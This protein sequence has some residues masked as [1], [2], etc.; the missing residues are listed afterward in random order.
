M[1][2]SN[3][4]NTFLSST[5]RESFADDLSVRVDER[6]SGRP[7]LILHG[8]AGP[9]SV[10]NLAEALAAQAH[11][12][13]PT[14]PGFEDEPRP[15]W[16]NSVDDLAFTYLDLLER[17]NLQDVVAIGFSFGGWIAA[18]LAVLNTTRLSGLILVGAVG[19]QVD[20]HP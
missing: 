8:A 17:L 1:I 3:C 12:L 16:F 18:E 19:I 4:M 5:R 14:H 15:E 2:R 10:S 7:V 20:E 13:V 9:R 6:G 11:V